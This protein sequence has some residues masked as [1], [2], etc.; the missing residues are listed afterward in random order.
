MILIVSTSG[1][2]YILPELVVPIQ[3]ITIT[4][5]ASLQALDDILQKVTNV[6]ASEFSTDWWPPA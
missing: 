3:R 2:A 4:H 5:N 1:T 6:P